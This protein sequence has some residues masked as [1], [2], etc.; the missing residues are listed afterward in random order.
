MR[1]TT[2]MMASR[3]IAAINRSYELMNKYQTQLE[4]Q[5]K[6][7]RPSDDPVVA[8]KGVKNRA[9]LA[10]IGQYIRNDTE[11]DTWVDAT[12]TAYDEAKKILQRLRELADNMANGTNTAVDREA[13]AKEISQLQQQMV[14]IANTQI[15]GNYIF[16]GTDIDVKPFTLNADGTV[17]FHQGDGSFDAVRVEVSRAGEFDSMLDVNSLPSAFFVPENSAGSQSEWGVIGANGVTAAGT[18]EFTVNGKTFNV[19]LAVGDS[20]KTIMSKINQGAVENGVSPIAKLGTDANGDEILVLTAYTNNPAGNNMTMTFSGGLTID[21]IGNTAPAVTNYQYDPDNGQLGLPQ[22]TV[23]ESINDLLNYVNGTQD[24]GEY[25]TSNALSH[26]LQTADQ[27]ID[28]AN[29]AVAEVG[30]KQNR[31]ELITTRNDSTELFITK[32]L[33]ENEDVDI[34]EVIMNLSIQESMH[35]ASLAVSARVIQPSLL[36]FLS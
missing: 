32:M 17:T 1:I 31:L 36:D 13:A 6:I 11:A 18:I 35:R 4:T 24:N 26:W 22:P 9:D 28:R 12:D 16:N 3:S 2:G 30:G 15:A 14:D 7:N 23:F 27:L 19:E 21:G 34:E 25:F 8:M 33:S 29:L 5:K 10:G 20:T